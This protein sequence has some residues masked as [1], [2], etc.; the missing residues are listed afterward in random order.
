MPSCWATRR[1][2]STS[3]TEQQ[4]ESEGP[5][6]SLSVAPTTSWPRSARSAAATEEST[7]PDMATS[8]RIRILSGRATLNGP[9]PPSTRPRHGPR[10]HRQ[11]P[12]DVGVG[13]GA[14]EGEPHGARGLGGPDAPWPRSTWLGSSAPLAHAEPGR[15]ADARRR[16]GGRGA[17]LV[18]RRRCAGGSARAGRRGRAGRLSTAPGRRPRDRRP[19]GHG[20]PATRALGLAPGAAAAR[21]AARPTAP[22]TSWVPLRR[23]CSCPPPWMTARARAP[24]DHQGTGPLGS[25]ELVGAHRDQVAAGRQL[26]HVEPGRRLHGLGVHHA[27]ARR[28]TPRRRRRPA[29]PCPPRCWPASPR[30]PPSRPQSSPSRPSTSTAPGVDRRQ[31]Q[32]HLRRATARAARAGA[33]HRG[34]LDGRAHHRRRARP[35]RRRRR[36]QRPEHGQVVGLGPPRGEDHLGGGARRAPPPPARASSSAPPGRHGRDGAPRGIGEAVAENGAMASATSGRAGWWRRG[37]GR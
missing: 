4:P 5:P 18:R 16:R 23:S 27:P 1:A 21:A 6:H 29:G 35:R 34:V 36:G 13:G 7:P 3:A 31:H 9:D 8:T 33:E 20:A 19:G 14:A 22:A 30:P 17:P 37:R 15:G 10:H 28:R 26:G 25:P 24:T 2:S 11:G 32:P 12:V